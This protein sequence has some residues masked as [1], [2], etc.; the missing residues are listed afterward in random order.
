MLLYSKYRHLHYLN[1]SY[2]IRFEVVE[3]NIKRRT[4]ER[5]NLTFSVVQGDDGFGNA[6]SEDMPIVY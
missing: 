3:R 4:A 6:F 5:L 2:T 1:G